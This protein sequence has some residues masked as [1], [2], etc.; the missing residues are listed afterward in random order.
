[1]RRD[2]EVNGKMGMTTMEKREWGGAGSKKGT[3]HNE[4]INAGG[5]EMSIACRFV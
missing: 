5:G 1:M 3:M 2:L 4:K